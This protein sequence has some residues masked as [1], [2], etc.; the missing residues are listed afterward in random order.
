MTLN[1]NLKPTWY[2][3]S[4]MDDED[5][6]SLKEILENRRIHTLTTEPVAPSRAIDTVQSSGS[7][8]YP[9]WGGDRPVSRESEAVAGSSQGDKIKGG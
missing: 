6:E 1:S 5:F 4:Y 2:M 3:K 9:T 8:V 7:D